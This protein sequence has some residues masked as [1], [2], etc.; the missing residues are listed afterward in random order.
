MHQNRKEKGRS[1]R[2][3]GKSGTSRISPAEHD[4]ILMVKL[5]LE[6]SICTVFDTAAPAVAWF[7]KNS[8]EC[9]VTNPDART[10]PPNRP[11]KRDGCRA[12]TE[13]MEM[14]TP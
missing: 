14:D 13:A 3:Y 12:Q 2:S 5:V 10:A 8:V 4:S 7:M 1:Q 9:T 11:N 6:N